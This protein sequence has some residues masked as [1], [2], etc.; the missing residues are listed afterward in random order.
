VQVSASDLVTRYVAY[1]GTTALADV[2]NN[3]EGKFG[4]P[5]LQNCLSST[6]LAVPVFQIFIWL[7]P[8]VKAVRSN[9]S[10]TKR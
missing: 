2:I 8:S 5:R 4:F 9:T 1:C 3:S 6:V 10:G 7:V